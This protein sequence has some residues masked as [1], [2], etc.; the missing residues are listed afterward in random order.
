MLNI[1]IELVPYGC[2]PL[3]KKIAEGI[4]YNDKSGTVENGKYQY[5]IKD[6]EI[7][8]E[9][10]DIEHIRKE[11]VWKLLYLVLK[12]IFEKGE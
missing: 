4:I 10:K 2:I 7:K 12:Q 9:G 1:K 6:G 11:S 8:Y 5:E 3:T